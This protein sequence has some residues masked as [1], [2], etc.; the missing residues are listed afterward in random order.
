M[1]S[2]SERVADVGPGDECAQRESVG[3]ALGQRHDLGLDV[4]VFDGEHLAGPPEAALDLV[5]D[6]QDPLILEDL[7]HESEVAVVRNDDPALAEDR[8]GHEGRHVARALEPDGIRQLCSGALGAL[9]LGLRAVGAP[10]EVRCRCEDDTR[11]VGAARLLPPAVA[12]DGE[13]GVGASVEA[14]GER[15]E[16]VSPGEVLGQAHRT[17]DGLGARAGQEALAQRAGC[18]VGQCLGHP[19]GHRVVVDVGAAV[20]ELVELCPG[21]RDH[22]RMTVAR[23]ADGDAAEAVEVLLAGAGADARAFR[24]L[25]LDRVEARDHAR[26]H[27]LVVELLCLHVRSLDGQRTNP[28]DSSVLAQR[29]RG[30]PRSTPRCDGSG[31]RVVT[32][33]GRV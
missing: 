11:H 13:R 30:N 33:L 9:G 18:D 32:T 4:V 7:L 27:V 1:G 29:L 24:P 20:D 8:L 6:E 21:G 15:R 19:A 3:D 17:F 14:V 22:L 31:Q 26:D 28:P 2:G 10:E 12:R 23:I 16:L 25:D 5:A